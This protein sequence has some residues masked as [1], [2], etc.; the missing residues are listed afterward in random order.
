[1]N[2]DQIKDTLEIQRLVAQVSKSD[3]NPAEQKNFFTPDA[4]VRVYMGDDEVF[5]SRGLKKFEESFR[6]ITANVKR[7]HCMNGQHII[8]FLTKDKATGLLFC[9]TVHV[10]EEN[11]KEIITDHCVYCE[12]I[13]EK[14]NDNWLI[15]A[16]D[17]HFMISDKHALGY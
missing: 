2:Q 10:T 9:R 12:D 6:Q 11:G 15:K 8:D 16:R 14:K 5:E 4:Q 3:L 1:M 7:G 17:A 13:Y